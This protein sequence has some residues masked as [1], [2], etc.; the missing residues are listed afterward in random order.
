M[1]TRTHLRIYIF[2]ATSLVNQLAGYAAQ[3]NGGK[4][5]Y[6][7]KGLEV[8]AQSEI[9]QYPY[10]NKGVSVHSFPNSI[11]I[12]KTDDKGETTYIMAIE[13]VELLEPV[14]EVSEIEN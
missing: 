4:K 7:L 6:G 5:Q 13:L 11:T 2:E 10:N 14:K 12:D 3:F 8:I 1:S 9:L